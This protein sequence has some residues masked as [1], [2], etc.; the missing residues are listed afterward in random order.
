M[1]GRADVNPLKQ[2][3]LLVF[4]NTKVTVLYKVF[5]PTH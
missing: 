5:T 4:F 2:L 1:N 3:L